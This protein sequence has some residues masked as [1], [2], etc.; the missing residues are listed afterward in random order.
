MPSYK[1]LENGKAVTSSE[2]IDGYTAYEYGEEPQELLDAINVR[3]YDELYAEWK[4]QRDINVKN[5]E[6][7]FNGKMYHGDEISQN[8][9]VKAIR[10]MEEDP[11]ITLV[12]WK[13]K[14]KSINPLTYENLKAIVKDAG[15]QTITLWNAG[16]PV[17]E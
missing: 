8:R 3:T 2:V 16:M 13:A 14:D 7:E 5:I 4:I 6:V 17:E 9:M 15:L 1:I 10:L 12:D 11:T